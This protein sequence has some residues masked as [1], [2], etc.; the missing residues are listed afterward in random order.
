[1]PVEFLHGRPLSPEEVEMLRPQIE[2]GFD[3]IAEVD[4][5]YADRRSQLALSVVEA[6][7]RGRLTCRATRDDRPSRL[8]GPSTAQ[9]RKA[10]GLARLRARRSERYPNKIR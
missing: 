1:M 2:E 6:S 10:F 4:E 8:R 5:R 7:A 9:P 3:N